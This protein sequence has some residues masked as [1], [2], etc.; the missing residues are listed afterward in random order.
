MKKYLSTTAGRALLFSMAVV[1]LS[2]GLSA[3]MHAE[4]VIALGAPVGLALGVVAVGMSIDEFP[5]IALLTVVTMPLLLFLFMVGATVATE[6]GRT[7]WGWGFVIL[8]LL[9]AAAAAVPRE[10]LAS[11]VQLPKHH[12]S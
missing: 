1:L 7:G 3:L 9:A 4:Y 10:P 11:G 2:G 12:T 5:G 6:E 8:G